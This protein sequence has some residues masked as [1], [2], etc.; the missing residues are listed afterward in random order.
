MDE[1]KDMI[2]EL[3]VR[4]RR[5]CEEFGILDNEFCAEVSYEMVRLACLLANAHEVDRASFMNAVDT[6]F[7]KSGKQYVDAMKVKETEH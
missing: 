6:V 7:T 1:I 2:T 4:K 5:E 3:L